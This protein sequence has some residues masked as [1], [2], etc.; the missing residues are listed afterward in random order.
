MI[1]NKNYTNH[2]RWNDLSDKH[3]NTLTIPNLFANILHEYQDK[4]PDTQ[5]L[6]SAIE[7]WTFD[8]KTTSILANHFDIVFTVEL[9]PDVN[10]YDQISYREI[11][12]GFSKDYDN[13][14]FLYGPLNEVIPEI[15][16]ELP[17]ERFMFLLDF[18]RNST[19]PI[20]DEI[21]TIK[22]YSR[23]KNHVFLI[24]DCNF[25]GTLNFPTPQELKE[26]LYSINPEYTLVEINDGNKIMLVY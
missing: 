5:N 10:P 11:H 8:A 16:S 15:L 18:H 3:K 25:L 23:N 24:D 17:D 6:R 20:K 14:T 1:F 26:L 9:Y 12:E 13:I 21:E 4:I 22:K 2:S 7:T 19:N